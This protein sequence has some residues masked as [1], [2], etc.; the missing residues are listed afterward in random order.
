MNQYSSCADDE[1][2]SSSE[3]RLERA[4][5]VCQKPPENYLDKIASFVLYLEKIRQ[6]TTY[7]YIYGCDE[8]AVYLDC[9]HSKTVAE[10]GSRQVSVRNTGHEKAHITVMLT[11]R[12]DGFKCK[13]FVL[14]PNK[15]PIPSIIEEFGKDL[16]LSWCDRSFFNDAITK[17]F[18]I[19]IMGNS[20]FAK[21]LLVWD[22]YRCHLSVDTKKV[23]RSLKIDTAIVPGGTTKFLQPADV[24]WNFAFKSRIRQH[25]EDFMLYGEKEY[26]RGGNMKQPPMKVTS[27][28]VPSKGRI[29]P[30]GSEDNLIHCLKPEGEITDG[31]VYLKKAREESTA[32][33][34]RLAIENVEIETEEYD[35]LDS[36]MSVNVVN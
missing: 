24:F 15:R 8:T 35:D 1:S 34:L 9:S 18:L 27:L 20:L 2:L 26:T 21:R 32:E 16:E 3:Y 36:D 7:D 25:Y 23:L 22:S 31:V 12:S 5:T 4:T 28:F 29:I 30:G 19:K 6:E 17:E 10:K 11:A 33:Q 14:L 13:P